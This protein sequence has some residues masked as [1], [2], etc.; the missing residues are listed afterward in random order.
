MIYAV[1]EP[2]LSSNVP[3]S[4]STIPLTSCIPIPSSCPV[5]T[6]AVEGLPSSDS[7]SEISCPVVSQL[8]LIPPASLPGNAYFNEF[9]SNSETI[10]PTRTVL[11]ESSWNDESDVSRSIGIER[12]DS[13]TVR[14]S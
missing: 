8:R 5:F 3:F 10:R 9:I 4:C 7:R 12:W 11:E 6:L 2:V 13:T 1:P 14:A